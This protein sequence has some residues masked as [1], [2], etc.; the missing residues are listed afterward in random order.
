MQVLYKWMNYFLFSSFLF[1]ATSTGTCV[2]CRGNPRG[3]DPGSQRD[4]D[5]SR[6]YE[7]NSGT[8]NKTNHF[9]SV[10]FERELFRL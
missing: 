4:D 5:S 10:L 8:G 3:Y 2:S 9:T 1:T 7:I 6:I